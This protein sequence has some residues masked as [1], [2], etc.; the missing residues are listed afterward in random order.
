VTK[1]VTIMLYPR[2]SEKDLLKMLQLRP[3]E[4]TTLS[5]G[6][7]ARMTTRSDDVEV[8]IED[9]NYELEA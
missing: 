9:E 1:T 5:N 8:E 6:Y 2:F 7:T 4:H 3:T